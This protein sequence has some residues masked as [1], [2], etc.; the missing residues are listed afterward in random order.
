[1]LRDGCVVNEDGTSSHPDPMVFVDYECCGYNYR[2]V[3]PFRPLQSK[4]QGI[5]PGAVFLCYG[6]GSR[7]RQ[8]VHIPHGPIREPRVARSLYQCLSGRGLQGLTRPTSVKS[9]TPFQLKDQPNFSRDLVTDNRKEDYKRLMEETYSFMPAANFWY[10]AWT[11]YY[12]GVRVESSEEEKKNFDYAAY[13]RDRL[14]MYYK[15]KKYMEEYLRKLEGG[16]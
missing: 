16:K 1:M 5:R 15:Q 11:I 9:N 4:F 14:V 3:F 2:Q 6:H 7:H 12:A 10:G 13:G 8:A